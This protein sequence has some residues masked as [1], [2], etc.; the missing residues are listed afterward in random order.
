MMRLVFVAGA[1]FEQ[2]VGRH[3]SWPLAVAHVAAG[4]DACNKV[5]VDVSVCRQL[6]VVVAE[7]D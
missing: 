6:E 4:V 5:C 2:R 7:R 1:R 3:I